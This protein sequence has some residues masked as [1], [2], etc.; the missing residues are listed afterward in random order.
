MP[1][2]LLDAQQLTKRFT[3]REEWS[4]RRAR[5]ALTAVDR[6]DLSIAPKETLGLVGESGC[7]KSTLGRLLLGL[8]PP[9]EGEVRFQGEPLQQLRGEM[10]RA[11]RR[12]V[13]VIFQDPF[14]SLNPHLTVGQTL[15]EPLIIHRLGNRSQRRRRVDALL[16]SVGL[17]AAYRDR[18]PRAL[19]G[20]ER[21]RVG[22]ARA[23]ATEPRLI[24]CDE[25]IASLDLSIGA[26]ILSLLQSLQQQRGLSYLFISHDLR[27]VALM[28]HRIAVMHLGQIV[29]LAQTQELLAHP[30]HPYTQVLLASATNPP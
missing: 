12:Q 10:L 26:Q 3:F 27:A 17:P 20:G 7:G 16:E 2:T 29:E 23:L 11:L 24:I 13:Q 8:I 21:Q 30:R 9:T 19:S 18:L 28:S 4:F 5:R 22:I 1:Q 25:P 6:V 14:S 15:E